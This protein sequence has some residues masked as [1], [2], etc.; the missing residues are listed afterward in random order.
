MAVSKDEILLAIRREAAA[1]GGT[2]PGMERFHQ[3]TGIKMAQWRGR[4]WAR[5]SDAVVEAGFA[6]NE[7]Q[8]QVGTD[9]EILR[10]LA[11]LAL[12]LGHYPTSAEQR[13]RHH[14]E[15]GFPSDK[16]IASRIG[17]RPVQLARL[18]DLSLTEL[19]YSPVHDMVR[20][21]LTA[22]GAPASPQEVALGVVGSVY[23]MRSGAH[24]K[25][26]RS[27]HVG[28]RSYEVAIQLPERLEVV[29]EI[30]TDDPE[31][32]ERYWHQRFA[33]KRT[34]GEWFALSDDDVRAFMRRKG[35]M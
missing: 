10:R 20:P 7:W 8:G 9:D 35:F 6:P 24:H 3:A 30:E 32:I 1:N 17:T 18:L 29:H 16:T 11:D 5:W 25:I 26:G 23:L 15:P 21:L 33:A 31:G 27:N 4:Y 13:L 34:N 12:E 28:R 19:D 22:T 14:Q 2:P